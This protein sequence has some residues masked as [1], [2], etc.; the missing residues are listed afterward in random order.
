MA[1]R[2]EIYHEHMGLLDDE[3]YRFHNLCKI[4]EYRK[5]DIFIGKNLFITHESSGCPLNMREIE[6]CVRWLFGI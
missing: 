6:K 3:E 1:N 5:N 2:R 4:E